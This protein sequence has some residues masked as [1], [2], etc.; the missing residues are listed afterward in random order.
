V[1]EV[2]AWISSKLR[3]YLNGPARRVF[4]RAADA[5]L[6]PIGSINGAIRPTN[7]VAITFDDGPD[8]KV[9]PP[10]LDLLRAR[11]VKATFFVLTS[12]VEAHPEII[13]QLVA[14][15][16][17]LALHFDNHDRLT[18]LP[19][20]A[21]RERMTAA[22]RSL[23]AFG[24]P[25]RFFRPPF[26]AQNLAIYRLARSKGMQVVTWGPI[27]EDWVEQPPARAADRA[28]SEMKGGEILL[29]HD[30]VEMPEGE[31]PPTFDRVKMVEL[32]LDGMAARKLVPTSVG[33]MVDASGAR[34]SPWFR[35]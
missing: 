29:L 35:L 20:P 13:R 6:F 17:E 24:A 30:G 3:P 31:A 4:R 2:L 18:G 5:V 14:D 28:L 34:L 33:G 15:G 21:V 16:H 11:G 25:I 32:M 23:Q 9:T 10:L 1:A 26:G 7:A 19:M 22:L 12:K 27:A 8:A